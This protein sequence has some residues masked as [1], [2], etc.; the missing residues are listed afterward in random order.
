MKKSRLILIIATLL[1]WAGMYY[2]YLPALNIH[3]EESWM[4]FV[5]AILIGLAL[6][7]WPIFKMLFL[8]RDGIVVEKAEKIKTAK[9]ILIVPVTLVVI[10]GVGMLLSSPILRASAYRELLDVQ[11][12]D[13]AS[14]IHEVNYNQIPI[15]DSDSAARLAEREM[16][17]M[18]D[19]VSQIGRAHV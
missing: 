4:F 6:N 8:E 14:D 7:F 5:V 19:M 18:V 10:Y 13:F 9:K 1:I 11:T 3:S 17:S 2:Y 12:S 16:G 15:L